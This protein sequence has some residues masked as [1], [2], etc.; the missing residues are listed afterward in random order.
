MKKTIITSALIFTSGFAIANPQNLTIGG[1]FNGPVAQ[2][3]TTVAQA[4]NARDDSMVQITGNITH[5]LGDDEY[6]FSDGV[7]NI[8]IEI[9]SDKWMGI[10]VTPKDKITIIGEIDKDWSEVKID[11]DRIQLT[12]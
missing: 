11:V 4:L 8:A 7:N 3:G 9:D 5:F 6:Q 12:M 1:G 2:M 10:A